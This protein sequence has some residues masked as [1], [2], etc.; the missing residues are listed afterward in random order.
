MTARDNDELPSLDE[1]IEWIGTE[2]GLS[3]P[4]VW[5]RDKYLL[6]IERHLLSLRTSLEWVD[7]RERLPDLQTP[8]LGVVDLGSEGLRV[9]IVSRSGN[10]G[11]FNHGYR[12][13][14]KPPVTYWQPLPPPKGEAP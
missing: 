1:C 3:A 7:V 9:D 10:T 5:P 12:I 14:P 4:N 2:D 11:E 8:V 13:I 6:A